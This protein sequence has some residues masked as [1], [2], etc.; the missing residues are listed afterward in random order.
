MRREHLFNWEFNAEL[1]KNECVFLSISCL[2][3]LE[4]RIVFERM[5]GYVKKWATVEEEGYDGKSN[6]DA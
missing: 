4:R 3:L 6:L 1:F 5:I 2:I